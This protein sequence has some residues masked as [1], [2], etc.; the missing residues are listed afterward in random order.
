MDL[1][2][3]DSPYFTESSPQ[4]LNI[5]SIMVFDRITGPEMPITLC[6]KP[7]KIDMR[8]NDESIEKVDSF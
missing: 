1:A 2:K 4:V 6:R 8:I 7:K 3:L 5:G